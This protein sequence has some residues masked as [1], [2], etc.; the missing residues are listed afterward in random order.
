MYADGAKH[1]GV[2]VRRCARRRFG[3]DVAART[4]TVLNHHLLPVF[5]GQAL[6]Q[7]AAQHV[8]GTACHERHDQADRFG[9]I[10]LRLRGYR[11]GCTQGYENCH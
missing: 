7:H 2:A 10:L 9:G 6:R 11:G 8:R 3:A 1:E 5:L 4:G